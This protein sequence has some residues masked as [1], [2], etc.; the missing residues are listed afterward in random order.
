MKIL[1]IDDDDTK[2]SLIDRVLK[3]AFGS[4]QS[5]STMIVRS[6]SE[7]MR[8]LFHMHFDLVVLDLMLP[9]LRT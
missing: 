4:A 6:I 5:N 3:N 9:Y 7:A 2:T 8:I 1:L